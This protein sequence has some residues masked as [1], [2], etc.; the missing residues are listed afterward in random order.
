MRVCIDASNIS[1]GGGVT[2]LVELLRQVDAEAA[3]IERVVL[4]AP[5]RTLAHVEERPWLAKRTEPAL[6]GGL[7]GRS[8]W[9]RNRLGS[10]ARADGCDIL[11][12]PGGTFATSFRP[13]VT[14]SRNLLPFETRE[15]RR[16]GASWLAAK[17]LA[18]RW[19]Q[20]RS[21][22]A[23]NGTIFLTHYAR[24]VVTA[25]TGPLPGTTALVPHG[26]DTRFNAAQPACRSLAEC[27]AEQPFRIVYVSIIDVYKHQ[28]HMARA[29]AGLRARGLPVCLELVGPAYIP[30]LRRLNETLRE[31]DPDG[32][33]VRLVGSV[34]HAELPAVYARADLAVF[35][36]SCENMPNVL[37]EMMASGVPI[38]CSDRGPM[39]EVLGD[40]VYFDPE[41]P[42]SIAAAI[43][44]LAAS[45]ALRRQVAEAA[46]H[47]AAGFTWRRCA[48]DTFA[49][50]RDVAQQHGD[51]APRSGAA[52]VAPRAEG[53]M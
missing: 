24:D 9:Q 31:V 49:F 35:A 30:A 17:F 38:A 50:L 11:F 51:R 8:M 13:V 37:L 32:V 5:A 47:R 42:A 26:V 52:A 45:P 43:E 28:D 14:M 22:K 6:D 36:S 44:R 7:L 21:F 18:L 40:G 46:A 19:T 3:G 53:G 29:V 4:W 48:T 23:A 27:S 25:C 2:H 15:W 34:P 12:V 41:Q 33:A 10:L 39:P 20:A 1:G 16:Y